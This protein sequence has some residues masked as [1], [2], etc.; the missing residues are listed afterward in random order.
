MQTHVLNL[1]P[2][3]GEIA[4][5]FFFPKKND[6]RRKSNIFLK[7]LMLH[8]NRSDDYLTMFLCSKYPFS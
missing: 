5:L 3:K 6:L 4:D 1:I 2:F 8:N 7:N